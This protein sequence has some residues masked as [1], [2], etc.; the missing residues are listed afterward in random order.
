MYVMYYYD[1]N[2]FTTAASMD[3]PQAI[4]GGVLFIV[5]SRRDRPWEIEFLLEFVPA[6]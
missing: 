3:Y 1:S 4:A 6:P 5:E 2:T